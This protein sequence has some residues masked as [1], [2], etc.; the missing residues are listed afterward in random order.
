[1]SPPA[2]LS[3]TL[4]LGTGYRILGTEIPGYLDTGYWVLD[5]GYW[6][7]GTA[8]TGYWVLATADTGYWVLGTGY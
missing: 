4:L 8:D 2:Q 3:T 6:I 7:L 1:M 5:T